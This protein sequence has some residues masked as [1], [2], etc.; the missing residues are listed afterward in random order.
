MRD[1]D[2][3]YRF[4]AGGKQFVVNPFGLPGNHRGVHN[5]RTSPGR[6]NTDVTAR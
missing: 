4:I 6:Y 3:T 2:K 1:G 5:Q